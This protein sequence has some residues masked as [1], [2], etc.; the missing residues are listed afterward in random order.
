MQFEW[1]DFYSEFAT[2][3]LSFKKDRKLLIDKIGAVYAAI[4]MKV[5][6]LES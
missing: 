6:E 1:I 2:K 3:L 4:D 5:P